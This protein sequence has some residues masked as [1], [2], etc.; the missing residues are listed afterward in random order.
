MLNVQCESFDHL[1]SKVD[2]LKEKWLTETTRKKIFWRGLC[3]SG[4][5][6]GSLS[7]FPALFIFLSIIG[8]QNNWILP[9]NFNALSTCHLNEGH[10]SALPNFENEN[11]I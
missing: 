2:R 3:S 7:K 5:C 9:R 8:L 4:L 1:L 11:T 6:L 10:I